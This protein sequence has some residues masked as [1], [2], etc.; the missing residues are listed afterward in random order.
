MQG[1]DGSRALQFNPA[2]QAAWP[3]AATSPKSRPRPVKVHWYELGCYRKRAFIRAD[4]AAASVSARPSVWPVYFRV[5][6]VVSGDQGA[7]APP[8]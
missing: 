2:A 3:T 1:G 8:A 5:R 7:V 6:A 4:K